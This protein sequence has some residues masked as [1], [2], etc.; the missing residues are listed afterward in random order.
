MLV[1][2][3]SSV[4]LVPSSERQMV[5]QAGRLSRVEQTIVLPEFPLP[6]LI[7]GRLWVLEAPFSEGREQRRHL[8]LQPLRHPV[9][10]P[11][12]L[13]LRGLALPRHHALEGNPTLQ[14]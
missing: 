12:P 13:R 3:R 11:G 5:E 14:L 1:M 8:H 10:Q 9:Q 4:A 2:E 6:T 7:M